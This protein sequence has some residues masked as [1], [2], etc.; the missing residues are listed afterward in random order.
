MLDPAC[1]LRFADDWRTNA[2]AEIV[3]RLTLV[4]VI[5]LTGSAQAAKPAGTDLAAS[6]KTS[7]TFLFQSITD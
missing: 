6:D 5:L 7:I 4:I 3:R 2:P 1:L